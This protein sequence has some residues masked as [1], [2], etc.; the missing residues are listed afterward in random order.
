M[1]K[2]VPV[3]GT[4]AARLTPPPPPTHTHTH[5]H[6]QVAVS[7]YSGCESD[8]DDLHLCQISPYTPT[9]PLD[10]DPQFGALPP[11]GA[12][13]GLTSST[14]DTESTVEDI[15]RDGDTVF[16]G[17][18]EAP[19]PPIVLVSS[20]TDSTGVHR[21][22]KKSTPAATK[23][24]RDDVKTPHTSGLQNSTD[25][26]PSLSIDDID[27]PRRLNSDA[28]LRP[29]GQVVGGASKWAEG[30][31]STTG[32]HVELT[33]LMA[34]T[35]FTAIFTED[36]IPPASVSTVP[37]LAH[38]RQT[39]PHHDSVAVNNQSLTVSAH[40]SSPEFIDKPEANEMGDR[41]ND[42]DCDTPVRSLSRQSFQSYFFPVSSSPV[43]IV[44]MLT[45]LACFTGSILNVLTPRLPRTSLRTSSNVSSKPSL[46]IHHR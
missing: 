8:Q 32:K 24:P 21:H 19:L 13:E 23:T 4:V 3:I 27:P 34:V 22:R 41:D 31:V 36:H 18:D 15:T 10:T 40:S 9:Q 1:Y 2:P 12:S 6:T 30:S 14:P 17:L 43:D 25:F 38:W 35:Y 37:E 33:I 5:T 45:R 20:Q 44:T 46:L 11:E 42:F 7:V 16:S 28:L 39:H 26:T 29:S